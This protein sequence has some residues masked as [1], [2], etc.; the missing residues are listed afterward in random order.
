MFENDGKFVKSVGGQGN[1]N[2]QFHEPWSI[3]VDQNN[4][5]YVADSKNHRVQIFE[6]I[7]ENKTS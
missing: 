1:G 6:I 7:Y 4:I 5:L 3:E 2:G